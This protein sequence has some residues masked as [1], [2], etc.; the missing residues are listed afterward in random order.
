MND[1]QK[2]GVKLLLMSLPFTIPSTLFLWVLF[3]LFFGAGWST[4]FVLI[5]WVLAAVFV[6]LI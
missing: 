6:I 4:F 5:G 1:K 2:A 3:F